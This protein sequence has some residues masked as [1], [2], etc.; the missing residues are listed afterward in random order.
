MPLKIFLLFLFSWMML[1]VAGQQP[2][3]KDSVYTF[4]EVAPVFPD[5][6][7]GLAKYLNKNIRL[8]ER[9][10]E[11][12]RFSASVRFVI[13]TFGCINNIQLMDPG[14]KPGAL[15]EEVMRVIKMMPAWKPGRHQGRKV[16]VLFNLPVHIS[17]QE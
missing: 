9:A 8:S 7:A 17:P 11:E 2:V 5:G 16:K 15:E 13:D 4:V 12:G 14:R 1:S 3:R 6:E 10:L